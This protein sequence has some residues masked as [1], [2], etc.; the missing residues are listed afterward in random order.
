MQPGTEQRPAAAPAAQA[1]RPRPRRRLT[2]QPRRPRR[3]PRQSRARPRICFAEPQSSGRASAAALLHAARVL[4]AR[5]CNSKPAARAPTQQRSLRQAYVCQG[6]K[7][8]EGK[9][10]SV[11]HRTC[12]CAG[13]ARYIRA[14]G[15]AGPHHTRTA[16]P[17]ALHVA[18]EAAARAGVC[19]ALGFWAQQPL[20]RLCVTSACSRQSV[21]V[22]ACVVSNKLRSARPATA[23]SCQ[24][25]CGGGRGHESA[26]T[27]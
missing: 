8:A 16:A 14:S 10:F 17:D 27:A 18:P 15:A 20:R 11:H 23:R 26:H 13:G 19:N 4:P 2:T 9:A 7:R 5:R 3:Q 25:R 24:A 21:G 12:V 1:R 22:A 6:R